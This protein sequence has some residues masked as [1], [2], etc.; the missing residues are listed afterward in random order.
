MGEI[1]GHAV[2]NTSVGDI[3]DLMRE[4]R[5]A[6]SELFLEL[7]HQRLGALRVRGFE[8]RTRVIGHRVGYNGDRRKNRQEHDEQQFCP[9]AHS[10]GSILNEI[11]KRWTQ[12]R[13]KGRFSVADT[14]IE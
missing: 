7:R 13:W 14:G 6:L 5:A 12:K 10:L 4:F 3:F 2:G 1:N 11:S 9:E 8:R